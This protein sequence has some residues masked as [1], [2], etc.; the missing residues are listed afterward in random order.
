MN[1]RQEPSIQV[2][3]DEEIEDVV[4]VLSQRTV[5]PLEPATDPAQLAMNRAA[6]ALSNRQADDGH[7]LFELEADATIPS[8][9]LL[10]HYFMRTVDREREQKIAKYLRRRQHNNGSWSLYEGGPGDISATVKAYF[11]LKLAGDLPDDEHMARTRNWVRANGG[12][13]AVNVFT[14]ITLAVFGQLPWRAVPAMPVEIMY[15]PSWW[16]FNLSK[17]SY[18][19][20][21]VIVPLLIIFAKRPVVELTEEQGVAELFLNDP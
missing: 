3:I 18:W 8:E 9:Y 2:L 21:C 13:E 19:S 4:E 17:V 15:L 7:W 5:H 14:R 12:A 10:L 11:A 16:F 1:K 6:K 20:R